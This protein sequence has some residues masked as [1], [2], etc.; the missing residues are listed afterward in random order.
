MILEKGESCFQHDRAA[1]AGCYHHSLKIYRQVED[2][3]GMARVLAA[4]GLIAHH[5]GTFQEAVQRYSECLELCR[6]LGDPRGIANALVELG[7]NS[8]RQ[9]QLKAG[10]MY[11]EEGIA[12]LQQIEDRAGV[13]RDYLELGRS[14]FWAGQFERGYA[15]MMKSKPILE[16][17]GIRDRQAFTMIAS[18]L[19]LSHLGKY[20]MSPPMSTKVCLL[21]GSLAP[22]VR[23]RWHTCY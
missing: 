3:W 22:A 14:C 18:S 16:D 9:G 19:A 2:T 17:L 20:K 15:L 13:A 5:A 10:Q 12:T 6:D 7:H 4:M 23:L 8:F 21:P 1:A 11:I